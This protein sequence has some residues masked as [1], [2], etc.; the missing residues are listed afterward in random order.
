MWG[1][2]DSLIK[3]HTIKNRI[4]T[5]LQQLYWII[6]GIWYYCPE[7]NAVEKLWKYVKDNSIKNKV[8]EIL[9]NLEDEVCQFLSELEIDVVGSICGSY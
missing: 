4:Y 2:C 5:T 8:F 9:S 6:G 1:F 7:L 3:D